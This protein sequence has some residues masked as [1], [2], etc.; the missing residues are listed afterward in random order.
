MFTNIE[1]ANFFIYT[2]YN[3]SLPNTNITVFMGSPAPAD[4]KTWFERLAAWQILKLIVFV[5]SS[6]QN[7]G[8]Q[9]VCHLDL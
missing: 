1:S 2:I 3:F 4:M 9:K 6:F 8:A 7:G 5:S